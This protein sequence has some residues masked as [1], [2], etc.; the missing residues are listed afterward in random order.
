MNKKKLLDL[1]NVNESNLLVNE[2]WAII[3][4]YFYNI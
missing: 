4:I 2:T 1:F 3:I